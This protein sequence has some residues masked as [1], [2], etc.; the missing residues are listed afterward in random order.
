M[1]TF[2]HQQETRLQ[3]VGNITPINIY[4]A[5]QSIIR[6]GKLSGDNSDR[7]IV[8][9][10]RNNFCMRVFIFCELKNP[11]SRVLIFCKWRVFECVKFT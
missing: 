11:I 1:L 2:S 4:S 9:V 10:K 8:Y 6:Q 3:L 7:S 5:K